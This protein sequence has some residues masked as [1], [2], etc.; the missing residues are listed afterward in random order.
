MLRLFVEAFGEHLVT[1]EQVVPGVDRSSMIL[2]GR[3]HA[4]VRK[5][6]RSHLARDGSIYDERYK[7]GQYDNRSAVPV[8]TAERAVLRATMGRAIHSNPKAKRISLFDFGF[9]TGR[10]TNELITGYARE[11]PTAK[12]L[13]VVAYDVSSVGLMK[14]QEALCQAGFAPEEPFEWAPNSTSGYIAGP[15]VKTKPTA[16]LR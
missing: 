1:L 11:Y 15:C 2:R 7:V 9:G 5:V 4:R 3:L 10:V 16:L 6:N 14:A 13:R 8:L 12:D